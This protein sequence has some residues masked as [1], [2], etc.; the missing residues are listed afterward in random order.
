MEPINGDNGFHFNTRRLHVDED[1]ADAFLLLAAIVSAHE[2]ENPVCLM[3]IGCPDL[4]TIDDVVI[5]VAH[6]FGFE[7]G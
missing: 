4:L 3:G 6:G 1:K 2:A 5:T 7:R